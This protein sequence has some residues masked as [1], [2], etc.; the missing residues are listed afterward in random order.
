[1]V[2]ICDRGDDATDQ[3]LTM[4]LRKTHSDAYTIAASSAIAI[5]GVFAV[6]TG[7]NF[8][9]WLLGGFACAAAVFFARPWFALRG[10]EK[11][12]DALDISY[13]GVSRSGDGGVRESVAWTDLSEVSVLTTSGGPFVEDVF[14]VMRGRGNDGVVIPHTVAVESGV[15]LELQS[16]LNDFDNAAFVSAMGSTADDVFVVWRAPETP[17]IRTPTQSGRMPQQLARAS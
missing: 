16:R 7:D 9:W 5:G 4:I 14:I 13:W 10:A 15:L 2:W 3:E 6:R 11:E 1:M 12:S 8:G 17:E